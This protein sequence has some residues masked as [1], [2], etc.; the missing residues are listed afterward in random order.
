MTNK[1]TYSATL[2]F[3][4]GAKRP[5]KYKNITNKFG[6]VIFCKK[7]DVWYINWYDQKTGTFENR[8]WLINDFIK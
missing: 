6:F 3:K 8:E 5:R 4:P 7:N 2:F 1:K